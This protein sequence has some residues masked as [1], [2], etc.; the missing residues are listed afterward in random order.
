[1]IAFFLI[2]LLTLLYQSFLNAMVLVLHAQ[3]SWLLVAPVILVVAVFCLSLLE[4]L[5]VLIFAGILI[6]SLTGSLTGVNMMLLTFL[7]VAGMA[8]SSWLGKPHWPMIVAFLFGTSLFYRL[9]MVQ[10]ANWGLLNLIVGPIL[11]TCVGFL[12]F[13]GLPRRVIKMD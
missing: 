3:S 5:W 12:I 9:M 11:D 10:I 2:L 6:D 8:M 1:M 7:G 4:G 13:Y